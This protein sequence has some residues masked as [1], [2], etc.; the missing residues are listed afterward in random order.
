MPGLDSVSARVGLT[1]SEG[2]I[3]PT[4][5][6]VAC[7]FLVVLGAFGQTAN[8][9]INGL[10]IDPSGSVVPNA[11]VE[12]KN[13]ETGVAYPTQTTPTGNYR[14]SNLPVGQ[15]EVSVNVPGFKAY[16]RK[17]IELAAAQVLAINVSLEVG[18]TGDAVTVTAE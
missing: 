3:M 7:F 2:R 11:T 10:V 1:V 4:I 6:R 12:A 16:T 9:T 5:R 13:V 8:S 17:G 14:I 15:Y 18:A